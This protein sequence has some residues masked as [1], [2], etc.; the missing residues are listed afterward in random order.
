MWQDKDQLRAATESALAT[1]VF[2]CSSHAPHAEFLLFAVRSLCFINF[3]NWDKFLPALLSSISVTEVVIG[4]GTESAT[5]VLSSVSGATCIATSSVTIS[6]SNFQPSNS[7]STL[8]PTHAIASPEPLASIGH[9]PVKPSEVSYPSQ[10][11][12]LKSSS[13][14]K[15]VRLNWTRQLS[16][17]I[18]L[19][20]IEYNLKPVTYADIF[21][22]MM[23]WLV[24]W[25]QQQYGGVEE[26][27]STNTFK[28][29]KVTSDW[30][31]SSLDVIWLLINEDKCCVPFYELL[32]SDL[33]FLENI[34]A[35]EALFT[36]ILEIHRR[37]DMVAMHMQMLDQ[38]LHCPSFATNRNLSQ[39]YPIISGES[40]INLR[41]APL[42]YPSVLGEP[43]HGEVS[44][45][46]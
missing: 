29:E 5:D 33:Q 40:M 24:N 36:M 31:H 44:M 43:L 46:P 37:R 1:L 15:G 45:F 41:A 38:H 26:F 20:G 25:E 8:P 16:C 21:S 9:S 13:L 42:T 22:H 30:I 6:S 14:V 17:K 34:P 39:F 4:Q 23:N 11:T 3:I 19:E 10:P 28:R 2:H 12:T 32:R 18:I 7:I 27:D 35:D